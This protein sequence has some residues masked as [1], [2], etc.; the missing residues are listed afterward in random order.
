MILLVCKIN[1]TD[2]ERMQLAKLYA[3]GTTLWRTPLTHFTPWDFNWPW[4]PPKDSGPPSSPGPGNAPPPVD[5][6]NIECGSII[7]CQ[8]RTLGES[9]P[10]VGT[11]YT[12]N[13]KSSRMPGAYIGT[14]NIPLSGD[15]LPPNVKRIVLDVTIAGQALHKNSI[16]YLTKIMF[17][18][19]MDSMLM[20][21]K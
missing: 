7:D 20:V 15:F 17:S 1:I 13:Y 16:R 10:I 21:V 4:G 9:I 18:I 14:V 8:N 5:K 19:G 2:E 12:I 3:I 6:P 11:P